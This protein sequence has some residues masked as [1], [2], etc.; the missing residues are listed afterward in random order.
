VAE[1]AVTWQQLPGGEILITINQPES[2][3]N[4]VSQAVL[5][6]LERT[7]AEIARLAPL[8]G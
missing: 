5:A 3:V 2:K 6:E 4:V 8:A 7:V 1:Q